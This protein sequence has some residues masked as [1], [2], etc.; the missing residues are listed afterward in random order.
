MSDELPFPIPG[1]DSCT[2]MLE[3]EIGKIIR[4]TLSGVII[5]I[6]I[7]DGKYIATIMYNDT[8]M[9]GCMVSSYNKES[10]RVGELQVSKKKYENSSDEQMF[11]DELA[12]L[13]Q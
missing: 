8:T 4:V 10:T 3:D 9:N 6:H 12:W 13:T 1:H 11:A 7:M 5:D 2:K